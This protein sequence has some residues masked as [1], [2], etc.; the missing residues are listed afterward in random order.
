MVSAK[1]NQNE[2][3]A[4]SLFSGTD[5]RLKMVQGSGLGHGH[6]YYQDLDQVAGKEKAG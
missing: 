6:H 3:G 2:A 5:D 4:F 1:V